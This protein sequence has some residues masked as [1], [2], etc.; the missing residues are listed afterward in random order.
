MY[1]ST[2]TLSLE[3]ELERAETTKSE[4]FGLSNI[5]MMLLPL[6]SCKKRVNRILS[7]PQFPQSRSATQN[8]AIDYRLDS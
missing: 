7:L 3:Y 8:L 1:M 6:V 5:T 2:L 4:K